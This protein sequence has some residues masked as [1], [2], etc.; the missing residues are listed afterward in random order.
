MKTRQKADEFARVAD[1]EIYLRN[2]M[3]PVQPRPAFVTG[4]KSRLMK[5]TV[6]KK[7]NRA[8]FQ[9]V[10]LALVGIA[11]SALLVIAGVRSVVTLLGAIGIIKL[12]RD[13]SQ[14][15][16]SSTLFR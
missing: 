15:K 11:G 16:P 7:N 3:Q 13:Q 8:V 9:N 14:N 2:V 6:A 12:L 10:V 4:L 1:T 5:A